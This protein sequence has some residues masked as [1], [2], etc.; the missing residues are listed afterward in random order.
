MAEKKN[1]VIDYVVE[2][3]KGQ[4]SR[5]ITGNAARDLHSIVTGSITGTT[6]QTRVNRVIGYAGGDPAFYADKEVSMTRNVDGQPRQIA[7]LS[8]SVITAHLLPAAEL[9]LADVESARDSIKWPL[10]PVASKGA[11]RQSLNLLDDFS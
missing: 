5:T 3:A 7:K 11:T 2:I 8:G 1:S 9:N 10:R 6:W 4:K